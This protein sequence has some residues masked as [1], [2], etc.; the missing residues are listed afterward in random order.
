M[1]EEI[2]CLKRVGNKSI[3][4]VIT[5]NYDSLLEGVF[6][7][8]TRFIGQEELIFSQIQG[9]GEIYKIHG[10]CT[11][12]DSI[13]INE[14]DYVDF[15]EKNPYLASKILTLFLEHPIV[16][17][18]YSIGDEN[19][20]NILRAIVR[21]LSK[22][23]I[24]VLKE[25]LIFIEWD[26]EGKN[27]GFSTHTIAFDDGKFINM[28]K[29]SLQNYDVLFEAMLQNKA[30]YNA[31]MLRKLKK[32]IYELV[33]TNEPTEKVKVVGLED[34]DKLEDIE[35]VVG[36][37]VIS[38]FG[39]KGYMGLT[40]EEIFLDVM[41]DDRQFDSN[42]VVAQSLPTLL[43][44]N[45]NSIPIYKYISNCN[46]NIPQKVEKEIKN[47]FDQL[48]SRTI[49]SKREKMTEFKD[50]E[51][52]DIINLYGEEKSLEYIAMLSEERINVDRLNKFLISFY[53]KNN[54]IFKNGT[55]NMKTNFRR[56][57]KIFDWLKYHNK[58]ES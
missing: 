15:Q 2:E 24:E 22:E 27:Q 48:L 25:R 44:H 38:E 37:G 12:P 28:T 31:P 30:K 47:N 52:D 40:A 36:V 9:V 50:K 34:D 41:F 53:G 20:R 56:L 33:L 21:C 8:Y 1:S 10:C 29:I 46:C 18:G 54:D 49:I 6:S 42:M 58:K 26:K 16:F 19:I 35:V 11:K 17:M 57:I 13:I 55:T 45:S 7:D 23:K 32:D 51:I 43:S 39:N 14:D 3:A 5:T 4:G